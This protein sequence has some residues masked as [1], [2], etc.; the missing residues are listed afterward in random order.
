MPE[1]DELICRVEI[2]IGSTN[3]WLIKGVFL[4]IG[5]THKQR[6][7]ARRPSRWGLGLGHEVADA[8]IPWQ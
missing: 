4:P 6:S 7:F 2:V 5:T 1:L 8:S 3:S